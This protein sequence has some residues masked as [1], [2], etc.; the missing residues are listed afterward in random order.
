MNKRI[1]R[2]C[3]IEK[4]INDFYKNQ[5]MRE[6]Y[7]SKCKE[8]S[9]NM[10]NKNRHNNI[11]YYREYDRKRGSRQ[12]HEYLKNY[13]KEYP[14]K[15]KATCIVNNAIR[16]KKLFKQP[17]EICGKKNNIHAHHD[18]YNQ[19]LNIR[20]L[21]PVCHKDWHIKNGEGKNSK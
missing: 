20:W 15:Y 7:D 8:C 19:P 4:D 3:L 18:D 9:K 6:G 14:K 12:N 13:R 1:C 2:I 11:E 21:C 16:D 5:S 10:I 17:C